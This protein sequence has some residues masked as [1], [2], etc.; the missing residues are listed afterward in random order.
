MQPGELTAASTLTSPS[1]DVLARAHDSQRIADLQAPRLGSA[2]AAS[3][4]RK[5]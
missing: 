1:V 3:A 4:A 2:G 5:R